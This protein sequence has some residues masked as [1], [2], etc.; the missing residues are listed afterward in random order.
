MKIVSKLVRIAAFAAFAIGASALVPS[1]GSEAQ[2]QYGYSHGG[3]RVQH[4]RVAPRPVYRHRH[5][6]PRRAYNRPYVRHYG[7]RYRPVY[8][9]P[10]RCVI[11]TRWVNTYYGPQLVRQ[12]VCSRGW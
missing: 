5:V 2:A 4:H 9:A 10:R 6:A 3:H 8:A 12:R 11:R 7:P 1:T